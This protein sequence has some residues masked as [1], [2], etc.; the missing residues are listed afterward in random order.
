MRE[1][2]QERVQVSDA[3]VS[4]ICARVPQDRHSRKSHL[5]VQLKACRS[6]L[7]SSSSNHLLILLMR[8]P[9]ACWLVKHVDDVFFLLA[10]VRLPSTYHDAGTDPL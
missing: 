7:V 3:S 5:V 8:V 1:V 4:R 9:H 6:V 2:E 10:Y